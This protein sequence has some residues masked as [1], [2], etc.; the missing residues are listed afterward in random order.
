M[1]AKT[2][3]RSAAR[4]TAKN[5]PKQARKAPPRV[6]SSSN[7]APFP[8]YRVPTTRQQS[9]SALDE[10]SDNENNIVPPAQ[11]APPHPYM[12]DISVPMPDISKLDLQST[13][14]PGHE[15]RVPGAESTPRGLAG[16]NPPPRPPVSTIIPPPP[17]P[18]HCPPST[19]AA[20]FRHAPSNPALAKEIFSNLDRVLA[21]EA[22]EPVKRFLVDIAIDMVIAL[23]NDRTIEIERQGMEPAEVDGRIAWA[24]W[25]VRAVHEG[26]FHAWSVEC[27]GVVRQV[28]GRRR[29]GGVF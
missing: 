16:M 25:A 18:H 21:R 15:E 10:A 7:A 3:Q 13:Q 1:P 20:I 5:K 8:G 27:G 29:E 28:E 4:K 24:K 22:Q 11:R 2:P 9:R 6:P 23:E 19:T 14:S 26:L 12:E 17:C